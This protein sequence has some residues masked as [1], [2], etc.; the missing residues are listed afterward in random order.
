LHYVSVI[1]LTETKAIIEVRSEP[2]TAVVSIGEEKRFEVTGDNYYDVYVKLNSIENDKS[3][4]T[5]KSIHEE[6]S[7][8]SKCTPDWNCA[9]WSNCVEG[10][11]TRTCEDLNECGTNNRKPLESK[12]CFGISKIIGIVVVIIIVMILIIYFLKKK[13]SEKNY[14][15]K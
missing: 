4:L 7:A 8:T 12:T 2:Q 3:N 1:N 13:S 14:V 9:G 15:K 6:I 10:T 5:I 11:K